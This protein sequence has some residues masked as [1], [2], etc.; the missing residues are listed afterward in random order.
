M[1]ISGLPNFIIQRMSV[2]EKALWVLD[3]TGQMVEILDAALEDTKS[4]SSL[5][6]GTWKT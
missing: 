2:A 4:Q 6:K 5:W 1:A 3:E